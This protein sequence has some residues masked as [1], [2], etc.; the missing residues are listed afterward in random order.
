MIR[1]FIILFLFPLLPLYGENLLLQSDLY[2][3][4]NEKA[5]Q[6]TV[7]QLLS[8]P[9]SS[10]LF[11]GKILCAPGTDSSF[12]LYDCFG[13]RQSGFSAKITPGKRNAPKNN[14][15]FVSEWN[16]HFAP[17]G[18]FVSSG[19]EGF[20][21]GTM[22]SNTRYLLPDLFSPLGITRATSTD[23]LYIPVITYQVQST[24]E[25]IPFRRDSKWKIMLKIS[26]DGVPEQILTS[27]PVYP[28]GRF[29]VQ[30]T[31]GKLEC[32]IWQHGEISVINLVYC[33]DLGKRED[34]SAV[35]E[36]LSLNLCC[37]LNKDSRDL[38]LA[39]ITSFCAA[40]GAAFGRLPGKGGK[41]LQYQVF[42]TV[43]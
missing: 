40:D 28:R 14:R 35:T 26:G 9:G 11:R 7:N 43:K 24:G 16:W 25:L 37:F 38:L 42:L 8:S 19:T 3:S 29:P 33:K 30:T 27:T 1:L 31:P 34:S 5:P 4:V 12:F 18:P 17:D 15:K 23:N 6:M 21:E 41:K 10:H 39:D 13:F 32:R 2:L 20:Y 36:Q 22:I